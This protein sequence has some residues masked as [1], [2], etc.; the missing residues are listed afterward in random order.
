MANPGLLR[1]G[2]RFLT[3][4]GEAVDVLGHHPRPV[5]AAGGIVV[6]DSD[7]PSLTV[8]A[9]Q[10]GNTGVLCVDTSAVKQ[11]KQVEQVKHD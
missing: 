4:A 7:A 1:A 9:D 10:D 2:A 5:L 11:V 8:I 3:A 6:D